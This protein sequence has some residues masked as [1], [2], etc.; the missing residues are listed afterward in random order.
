MPLHSDEQLIERYLNG[1]EQ[2][3]EILIE[4]HIKPIYR[5]IYRFVRDGSQAQDITQDVFVRMWRN[6]KKFDR[7]RNFNTWL[8]AIAK[9]ACIDFLKKKKT[10]SFSAFENNEGENV[11]EEMLADTSPLPDEILARKSLGQMLARATEMLSPQYRTVLALHYNNNF[12]FREI[13]ESLSEPLDTVKSRHRRA[14][15]MLK[16]IIGAYH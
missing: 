13:A 16:R 6:I 7:K 9:H 12:T 2:S 5:F 1:D 15:I 11:V 14:L 10:I 4:R 3:L 8:Y